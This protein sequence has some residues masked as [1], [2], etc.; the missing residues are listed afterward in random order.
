[1]QKEIW[2]GGNRSDPPFFFG[3]LSV[4]LLTVLPSLT[5]LMNCRTFASTSV[6]G[7]V[8][9]GASIGVWCVN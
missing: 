3:A 6:T 4:A 7:K 9:Y 2:M 1:M 5:A 8:I